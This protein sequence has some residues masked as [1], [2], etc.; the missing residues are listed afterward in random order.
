MFQF[1]A[2]DPKIV[3]SVGWS[4]IGITLIMM[5]VNITVMLVKTYRTL[6]LTF[7]RLIFKLRI[8]SLIRR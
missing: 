4:C 6:R 2:D 1:F 5:L 3:Y 7:K 8:K